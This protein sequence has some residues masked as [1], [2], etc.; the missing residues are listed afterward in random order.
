MIPPLPA[1][2]TGATAPDPAANGAAALDAVSMDLAEAHAIYRHAAL[3]DLVRDFRVGLQLA[4][5]RTFA[6]PRIAGLLAHTGEIG[7]Q[8]HKRS[9]DTGLWMYELIESGI[10][11]DRG[12]RVI[13]TLNRM[14]ARWP[15]EQE[16]YRYVLLTFVIVPT[17]WID[18]YGPRR[19]TALEKTAITRFYREL[20]Q[21]MHITDL[22]TSYAQAERVLDAYEA[23]CVT[24]SDAGAG[25][26]QATQTVMAEQLPGPLKPAA[27][28]LTRLILDDH[29]AHAVGLRP[30]PRAGR[31][32]LRLIGAVRGRT[33]SRRQLRAASWFRPGR[34]VEGVYP[35]GYRLDDLGPVKPIS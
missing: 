19:L 5:Y 8:P 26:M 27:S 3:F 15:I 4:F 14:H 29:V 16:D 13:N 7:R 12:R 10:D 21:R 31:A 20:G 32:L 30:A 9:I 34:A 11:S 35:D 24:Y 17:R 6:V 28:W 2:T 33:G 22:P 23:R 25:L 1:A 18:T